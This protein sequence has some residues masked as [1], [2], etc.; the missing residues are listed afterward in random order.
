[1]GART[2]ARALALL[3]A[4]LAGSLAPGAAQ[5]QFHHLQELPWP[6]AADTSQ[7]RGVQIGWTHHVDGHTGWRSDRMGLTLTFAAGTSSVAFVR[8]GFLRTDTAG[9][10]A[11]ERWPGLLQTGE[12][13]EADP[14]WPDETT[15]LGFDRPEA[16]VLLPLRLPG[17]GAGH[18]GLLAGL[19]V[20]R[21]ALY[22][23]SAPC[24]PL[25]AEW[26]RSWPLGPDLRLTARGGREQTIASTRDV[27]EAA[28]F[29]SGWR[30]GVAVGTPEDVRRGVQLGWAARE[31]AAGHHRRAA[32]L[33]GWWQ[34][35]PGSVLQLDVV[36]DLG[37]RAERFAEWTV[38]LTWRV[39]GLDLTG[40]GGD[41]AGDEAG[42]RDGQNATGADSPPGR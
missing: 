39:A 38:A 27:L 18:L 42:G 12:D 29:P 8:G 23:F 22:P 32:R 26:R 37:G 14:G 19:P 35:A 16:G 28:A 13:A 20:G 6:A 1:M 24:I 5:A 7:R 40:A 25:L 41:G 17:L 2:A 3:G 31:L 15:S 4:L 10:R 11:A 34:A 21:D 9:L 30:Y 33:R 36:R